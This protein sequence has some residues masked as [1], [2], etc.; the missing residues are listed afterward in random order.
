MPGHARRHFAVSCAKM[1]EPID[2]PI[3]FVDWGLKEAQVQ[4]Y[5][6]GGANV[7]SWN[8]TLTPAGKYDRTVR[9]RRRC[10]LMSNYSHHLLRQAYAKARCGRI[11]TLY[12]TRIF[13]GTVSSDWVLHDGSLRS[14]LEQSDFWTQM[15]QKVAQRCNY[16]VLGSLTNTLSS[17]WLSCPD[18]FTFTI[19]TCMTTCHFQHRHHV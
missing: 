9:L 11:Q 12:W 6:L 8:G 14:V 10:G 2:L 7:L 15:F 16:G 18:I 17:T 19:T 13:S 3:R 5:S 4:S 1:A